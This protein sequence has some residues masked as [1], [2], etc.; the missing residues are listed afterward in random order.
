MPLARIWKISCPEMAKL[1]VWKALL[2]KLSTRAFLV[3]FG[4]SDSACARCKQLED[5]KHLFFLRGFRLGNRH[6]LLKAKPAAW[7]SSF[8]ALRQLLLYTPRAAGWSFSAMASVITIWQTRN[9]LGKTLSAKLVSLSSLAA[10]EQH[11][12][13]RQDGTAT[14]GGP[15]AAIDPVG[16]RPPP[17]GWLKLNFSGAWHPLSGTGIGFLLHDSGGRGILRGL[18][19]R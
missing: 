15:V 19:K 12:F 18:A 8:S 9:R 14:R 3:P 2:G 1:M 4:F 6:R 11:A 13:S 17:S 16:W 7:P 10:I 5:T